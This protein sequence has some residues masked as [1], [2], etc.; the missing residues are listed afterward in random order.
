MSKY[1]EERRIFSDKVRNM[2]IKEGFY[3]CGTCE[4]YSHLLCVLCKDEEISLDDVETIAADIL[5]H[6]V[7]E[8][9]AAEYGV[10]YDELLRNVMSNL[11]NECC[12]TFV[13]EE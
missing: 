8:E 9:K 4:E 2:C 6:S 12:Y 5:V 10:G 7:W 1:R 3:T 13:I 11:I